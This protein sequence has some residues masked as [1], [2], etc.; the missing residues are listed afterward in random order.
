MEE[1]S[2]SSVSRRTRDFAVERWYCPPKMRIEHRG[3]VCLNLGLALPD[4]RRGLSQVS[5][6]EPLCAARARGPLGL[7]LPRK[8][9]WR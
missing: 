3:K 9:Q 2:C 4:L 1:T 5:V 8:P 7:K 6:H